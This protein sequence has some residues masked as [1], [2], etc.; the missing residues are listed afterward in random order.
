MKTA[1]EPKTYAIFAHPAHRKLIE[2]LENDG[3]KVFQFAPLAAQKI[4][5]EENADIITDAL[6]NFD[7]IVFSDVYAV[8]YFLQT[9]NEREIDLFELDAVRILAFG[10]AVA[11][12]LRFVQLHAD[13]ITA[14]II[15]NED[16]NNVFSAVINYVGE[17]EISNTKFLVPKRLGYDFELK[18]K[19]IAAGA[20]IAELSIYKIEISEKKEISKLKTLLKGGAIDE[21]IF[22]SPEDVFCLK[23]C[24][25][26]EILPEIMTETIIIATN[27]ITIRTLIENK[28]SAPRLYSSQK[29]RG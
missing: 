29:K 20:E 18:D 23:S 11:D 14:D 19:L 8:E 25:Y 10:E 9:L 24:V 15:T 16:T 1:S 12:R 3:S 17:G 2:E 26:P 6:T 5:S 21:F 13:I 4:E 28:L 22:T 27:E 7:W